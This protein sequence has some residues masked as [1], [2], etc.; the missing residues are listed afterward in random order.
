MLP[1][2]KR[3]K[4]SKH[5]FFPF[6]AL[7][8]VRTRLCRFSAIDRCY[9]R[10]EK[11]KEKEKEKKE[12]KVNERSPIR[13][14]L[15]VCSFVR[16]FVSFRDPRKCQTTHAQFRSCFSQR[17]T[18]LRP[19]ATRHLETLQGRASLF[20]VHQEVQRLEELAE[21]HEFFLS[22]GAP[23]SL[24]VLHAQSQDTDTPQ[25]SRGAGT[26][27][28][29]AGRGD[30]LIDQRKYR[31][32]LIFRCG[33]QQEEGALVSS[34]AVASGPN[35]SGSACRGTSWTIRSANRSLC[36]RNAARVTPGRRTYN[37]T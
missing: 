2:G 19:T 1:G 9:A 11:E 15:F 28:L 25:V 22:N 24:P 16:T 4:I 3:E 18:L 8:L 29:R 30:L 23:L 35:N 26:R 6:V 20:E 31:F 21:A 7:P 5:L 12:R 17:S 34:A 33:R 13:D 10:K 32:S 27:G 37:V 14:P 36:A